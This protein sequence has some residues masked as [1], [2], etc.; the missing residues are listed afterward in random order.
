MNVLCRYRLRVTIIRY[1]V[2][3]NNR[4]KRI[5]SCVVTLKWSFS[6]SITYY[7]KQKK[8]VVFRL[9]FRTL[10]IALQLTIVRPKLYTNVDRHLSIRAGVDIL[11]HS[12][13]RIHFFT[14]QIFFRLVTLVCYIDVSLTIV[15]SFKY[16][17]N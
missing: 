10:I 3:V 12:F 9:E 14:R 17:I 16:T 5:Y 6:N 13:Y 4:S 1:Y 15:L 7:S 2:N 8:I 11:C